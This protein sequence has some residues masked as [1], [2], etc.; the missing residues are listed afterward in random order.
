M[1]TAGTTAAAAAVVTQAI[2]A[3]GAIVSVSPEDFS[4]IL[5]RSREPL[6]VRAPGGFLNRS[7]AYLTA[8]KGLFFYCKSAEAIYLPGNAE[9]VHSKKI[10]IPG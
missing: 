1:N 5:G 10:W 9:V 7:Y 3:S 4:T 8:Y 6:V 2:K